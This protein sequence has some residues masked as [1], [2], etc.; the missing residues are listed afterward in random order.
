[1]RGA[2]GQ[3]IVERGIA[4]GLLQ[5]VDAAVAPVVEHDDDE[6]LSSMTEVAISEFIIR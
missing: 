2:V 4:A 6:F 3:H 1:M 5:A